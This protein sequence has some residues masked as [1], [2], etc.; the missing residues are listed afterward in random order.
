MSAGSSVLFDLPGPKARRRHRIASIASIAVGVAV[1]A[2]VIYLMVENEQFTA[3]QLEVFVTPSF[4]SAIITGIGQTLSAA[5]FAIVLATLIG[6]AFGLGKTSERAFV[7]WPSWLFVEFFRAV[8]VLVL[9]YFIFQTFG[10]GDGGIGNF[11][12]L[13]AGLMLYNG[14]VLAEVL[15]A[16]LNAV[17]KGQAEAA[18]AIGMRKT[19]VMRE[20]M[21]PQAV[22]IMLPAIISQLVVALKDT[23]LGYAINANGVSYVFKQIQNQFGNPLW[24]GLIL[25]AIYILLNIVVARIATWA[26][27]KLVGDQTQGSSGDEA[28]KKTQAA[29]AGA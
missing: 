8:P 24:V 14:A 11:W 6:L 7:R 26:S 22:R 20:V 15:R 2:Y 1:L 9:I 18:Y 10:A 25:A 12:S 21:V 13:V 5:V 16:G 17:P 23:S 3:D 28:E 27:D 19:Q 29:N 4:V